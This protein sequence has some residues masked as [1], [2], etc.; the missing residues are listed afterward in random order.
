MT[1]AFR[2]LGSLLLLLLLLPG[3]A[4]AAGPID[5]GDVTAGGDGSG[6]APAENTGIDPRN[7]R[8]T[9]NTIDGPLLE[10]DPAGD[11]RNPSPGASEY[12]DS[13]FFITGT[14]IPGGVLPQA[15]TRS[16]VTFQFAFGDSGATAAGGTSGGGSWNYILRDRNGGVSTLPVRVGGR[17]G[18]ASAVGIHAAA[19][20]TYDLAALRKRHGASSVGCFSAFWGL[21][22]CAAGD[23]N[24]YAILSS[25][26]TGVL[27]VR[28]AQLSGG[29]GAFLEPL[30]IP[31]TARYLTLATGANGDGTCDHGTF[32]IPFITAGPCLHPSFVTPRRVSPSIVAAGGGDTIT[33]TGDGFTSDLTARV[34]GMPLSSGV[35]LDSRR[36]RGVCP[37]LP[38]GLHDVEVSLPAGPPV[39]RLPGAVEAVLATG[40]RTSLVETFRASDLSL[41]EVEMAP[42]A[43]P[44]T[45]VTLKGAVSDPTAHVG[46]PVLPCILRQLAIPSGARIKGASLT[47]RA[48]SPGLVEW[49]QS[50]QPGQAAGRV[51]RP[52]LSTMGPDGPVY[53]SPAPDRRADAPLGA[54]RGRLAAAGGIRREHG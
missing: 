26:A 54:R 52:P 44:S 7:G 5:L 4:S 42:D 10:T 46:F 6:N 24:L 47:V 32:A 11:G 38:A 39:A 15:I 45:R 36:I 35:I 8:F 50:P 14:P 22:D 48:T 49:R 30:E 43:R 20:I 51:P 28:S 18:F 17:E 53:I 3:R 34:G 1:T 27:T 16:G 12:V 25:D 37:A 13:V 41:E 33:I 40:P 31:A 2:H 23:V 21:D 19:G 29:S 9:T